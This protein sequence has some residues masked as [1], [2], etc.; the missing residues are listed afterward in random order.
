MNE[1]SLAP[2]RPSTRATPCGPHTRLGNSVGFPPIDDRCAQ[3]TG[4][5]YGLGQ[6]HDVMLKVVI[7][8]AS[9]R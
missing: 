8:F 9:E 1:F 6:F 4:D 5:S 3:W 7:C 2:K